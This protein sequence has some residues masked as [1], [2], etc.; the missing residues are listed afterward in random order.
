MLDCFRQGHADS[1]ILNA[2]G[3]A[4]D[5]VQAPRNA[6][7]NAVAFLGKE[8]LGIERILLSFQ[9]LLYL[10]LSKWMSVVVPVVSRGAI[11]SRYRPFA[12]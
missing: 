7:L 2:P 5:A 9:T 11:G 6:A 8:A 3:M 12:S 4:L 10:S 1:R